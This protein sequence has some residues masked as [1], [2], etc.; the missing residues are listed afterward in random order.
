M[1]ISG[2]KLLS[3]KF[4]SSFLVTLWVLPVSLGSISV[5][6]SEIEIRS[7]RRMSVS[8]GKLLLKNSKK[9]IVSF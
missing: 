2:G 8:G 7:R 9:F 1:S 3:K 5:L 6:R 4:I